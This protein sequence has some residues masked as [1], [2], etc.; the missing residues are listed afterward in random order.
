MKDQAEKLRAVANELRNQNEAE[1]AAVSNFTLTA[2][3][4]KVIAITSGKGGVGK[5]TLAVNLAISLCM[6]GKRVALVDGDLGLANIDIM[7]GITPEYTLH[8]LITGK[9]SLEEIII[10]GLFGLKIIPGWSGIENLLDLSSDEVKRI[11]AELSKIEDQVDYLIIDT[12]AGISKIITAFI[13]AADIVLLVTTPE[14]TSITD[15]YSALKN[16]I[17]VKE[18]KEVGLI[19]NRV[20]NRREGIRI[21]ARLAEVCEKF[22]NFKLQFLG[23][24]SNNNIVG[25]AVTRQRPVISLY[26]NSSV[27][28]EITAIGRELLSADENGQTGKERHGLTAFFAKVFEFLK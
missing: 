26:P 17:E 4:A 21:A 25:E 6:N 19:V 3:Q 28:E 5:S 24:I 12:G 27:V 18:N 10:E 13:K 2:N 22:L 8:H 9:K 14:P 7:L 20:V 11:I 23:Y 15:A 1:T 16:V